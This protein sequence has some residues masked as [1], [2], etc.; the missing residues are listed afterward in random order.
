MQNK[1][2]EGNDVNSFSRIFML[3]HEL[4]NKSA[5]VLG[6]IKRVNAV[7]LIFESF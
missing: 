1:K 7:N 6:K 2:K 3:P 5:H 4:N